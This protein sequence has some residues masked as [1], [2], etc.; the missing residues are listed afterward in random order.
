MCFVQVYRCL[1]RALIAGKE[2][3]EIKKPEILPPCKKAD[4]ISGFEFSVCRLLNSAEGEAP[5][6]GGKP[7]ASNQRGK[8]PQKFLHQPDHCAVFDGIQRQSRAVSVSIL[9]IRFNLRKARCVIKKNP[10]FKMVIKAPIIQIHGA[11]R[12]QFSITEKHLR[13]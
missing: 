1:T 3:S 9:N 12:R 5:S 10:T 2:L 4:K 13:V 7:L 8:N 11:D 6:Y